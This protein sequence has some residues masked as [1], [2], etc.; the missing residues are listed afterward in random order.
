[1]QEMN[2]EE[3][4]RLGMDR[5]IARRDFLGGVALAAGVM[6]APPFALGSS[7]DT[8]LTAQL[9]LSPANLPENYP[10]ALTGLRGQYPARSR[11][12]TR[13]ATA[14]IAAESLS[15]KRPGK[16]TTSWSSAPESP[17]C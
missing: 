4:K 5:P 12:L 3:G 1:M 9:P 16:S 14:A 11:R 13:S 10:P 15:V 8:T 6:A 7:V 17:K 2:G